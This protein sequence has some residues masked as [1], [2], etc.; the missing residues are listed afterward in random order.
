MKNDMNVTLRLFQDNL[1]FSNCFAIPCSEQQSVAVRGCGAPR[2]RAGS[3]PGRTPLGGGGTGEGSRGGAA[4]PRGILPGLRG[5]S[6]RQASYA[7]SAVQGGVN[8]MY[9]CCLRLKYRDTSKNV[10]C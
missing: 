2:L 4:G 3:A 7:L 5:D 8:T 6:F 1:D 9:R 10:F